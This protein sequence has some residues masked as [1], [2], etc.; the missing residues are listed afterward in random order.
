MEQWVREILRCPACKGHLQDDPRGLMC[1][2]CHLLYPIVDG[3]PVLLAV[4]AQQVAS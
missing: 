3:I 4:E 2:T 1:A